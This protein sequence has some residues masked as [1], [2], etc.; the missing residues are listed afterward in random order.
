MRFRH[1][2]RKDP[3]ARIEGTAG[4]WLRDSPTR[5]ICNVPAIEEVD[6][7]GRYKDMTIDGVDGSQASFADGS[8]HAPARCGGVRSR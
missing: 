4:A 2:E 5:A 8:S 7:N 3:L 1:H 6:M